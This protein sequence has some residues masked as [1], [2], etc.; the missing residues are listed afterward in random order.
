[1]EEILTK[2]MRGKIAQDNYSKVIEGVSDLVLIH[3]TE[4]PPIDSIIKS[5][6]DAG[7]LGKSSFWV[8]EK[9]YYV[10]YPSERE[11]VH[12]CL[13]GEVESHNMG[14][15]D[16]RKYAIIIP[17]K[18]MDR[19]NIVGGN[20]VDTYTK[21]SVDIPKGSYIL[22][23]ISEMEY[24]KSVTNNLQV[25]GYEGETV[26][27][28][29]NYFISQ[30]LGYKKETIGEWAWENTED[31]MNVSIIFEEY[32]LEN[33]SHSYSDENKIADAKM[34]IHAV[35]EFLKIVKEHG[36]IT[37]EKSY[38]EISLAI[39]RKLLGGNMLNGVKSADT[40]L[41][42]RNLT[43]QFYDELEGIGIKIPD[44]IKKKFFEMQNKADKAD[45]EEDIR[46][47]FKGSSV[48]RRTSP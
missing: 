34:G 23:P 21:G 28:Y 47:N 15:F 2:D 29:A 32:G 18:A 3:K 38:E 24:L 44:E 45:K 1:M 35:C 31:S 5:S 33:N 19:S 27:G 20:T 10:R 11:T 17:F 26:D 37:D 48:Y 39:K 42:D 12:F 25:V 40:I 8:G 7:A 36:I 13:N 22:C 6:K 4:Y 16:N 41:N 30:V 14:D 43:Q 9:E 46:I